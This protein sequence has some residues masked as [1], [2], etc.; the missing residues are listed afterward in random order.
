M[1]MRKD[2]SF[3]WSMMNVQPLTETSKRPKGSMGEVVGRLIYLSV[4]TISIPFPWVK[5]IQRMMTKV[6]L[7]NKFHYAEYKYV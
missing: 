1:D 2:L 4:A 7:T 5:Y 3:Q 6:D